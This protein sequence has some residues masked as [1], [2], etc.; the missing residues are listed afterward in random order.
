LVERRSPKPNAGGSSPSTPA[1]LV[2]G[3]LL[4]ALAAL[5]FAF[6]VHPQMADYPSHLARYHVM[7]N[8]ADS[9]FLRQYY[10]FDWALRGNLG[11]DLLMVPLG[12]MLGTE[13]AAWLIALLLPVLVGLGIV[14]VAWTLRARIGAGPLLAFAAV[15]SPAMAM[16][17]ANFSLSLALALLAFAGWVRLEA[18]RWRAALFVPLGL[19]VWL[20]HSAGWGVLGVL[21]FGHEWHRLRSWRALLAPWPLFPPFLLMLAEPGAG[22]GLNYGQGVMAY[23]LGIWVKA[24]AD[25]HVTLDVLSV[26]VMIGAILLAARARALDGRIGWAALIVA[27]LSLAMPRHFGGGD[28]ADLRLVPV[29]LMLGCM[30]IDVRVPRWL[31]WVAPLLFVVR[32]GAT[33]ADWREQSQVLEAALPAL[34]QLPRGARLAAAVPY[35][36]LRWGYA[37]H[38]HAGSYATLYRD[39]LV[40]THFALPGVHML[41]VRGMGAAFADPSQQVAARPGEAVDLSRFAPAAQADYLWY[42]GPNAVR[43]LPAGATV[44]HRAPGSLLARLAKVPD[45]R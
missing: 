27:L 41:R 36:N 1:S 31:V 5:P 29:A 2:A 11:V 24:L 18:W 16:G 35:D 38:A 45:R 23:K 12:Q 20:C 44:I 42:L 32:L 34:D 28:L 4:A 3:L 33:S 6:A 37:P 15:W 19:L 14:A 26:L 8:G 13:R 22:S 25:T 21:V 40:N 43:A 7:L 9:P 10:S 30:A 17:F 39:A